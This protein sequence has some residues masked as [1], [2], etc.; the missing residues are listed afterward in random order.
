MRLLSGR[1]T[2]RAR[3][4]HR[5]P[6][7]RPEVCPTASRAGSAAVSVAGAG[8]GHEAGQLRGR[9]AVQR[10]REQAAGHRRRGPVA[11]GRTGLRLPGRA[12]RG[13]ATACAAT[14]SPASTSSPLGVRP[15]PAPS[16]SCGRT[17]ARSS[18]PGASGSTAGAVSPRGRGGCHHRPTRQ[19]PAAPTRA[20]CRARTAPER[21]DGRH[22]RP[23]QPDG[24]GRADAEHRHVGAA[25]L[26][27]HA[28]PGAGHL[29]QVGALVEQPG[30]QAGRCGGDD[31]GGHGPTLDRARPAGRAH[32]GLVEVVGGC[33]LMKPCSV[34]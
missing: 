27:V 3:A 15:G 16:R 11:Q 13:S 24:V 5:R 25:R 6:G 18:T 30:Q 1:T 26:V 14:S 22:H 23:G 12:S 10:V 2:C 33:Y 19:V 34:R 9:P 28:D 4:A 29:D 31:A 20:P 8:G 7:R 17:A 21:Y 32:A